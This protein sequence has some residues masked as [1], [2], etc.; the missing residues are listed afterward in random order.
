MVA[1]AVEQKTNKTH[2]KLLVHKA[3]YV[4]FIIG[5]VYAAINVFTTPKADFLLRRL[6]AFEFWIIIG[7]FCIYLAL[8][9]LREI[10]LKNIKKMNKIC[11]V[12]S[13]TRKIIIFDSV[14]NLIIFSLNTFFVVWGLSGVSIKRESLVP[15]PI[16]ITNLSS[17]RFL[18]ILARHSFSKRFNKSEVESPGIPRL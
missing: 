18:L 14:I 7:F 4:I 8:T 15:I 10:N 2:L 1:V 9:D 11:D 12:K 5:I 17:G 16:M 13:L 3:I 6:Y